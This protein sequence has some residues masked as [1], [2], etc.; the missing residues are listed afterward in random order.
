MFLFFL[1]ASSIV[2]A[3]LKK[4]FKKYSKTPLESNLSG[5]E[6]A[7]KMLH[8]NG[9]RN[10]KVL[11][12]K[13]HLSD[14]YNPANRTVNL[15]ESV[16]QGRN[17]A[18]ASVAAH[19]CGHAVQ[20]ARSYAPLKLRSVLVPLQNVS[21]KILNAV[22]ITMF[23]GA[24]MLPGFITFDLA[25]QKMKILFLCNSYPTRANPFNQLFIKKMVDEM[26]RQGGK[27][28]VGFNVVFYFWGNA[29]KVKNPLATLVKYLFYTFS[30]LI[31]L[32]RNLKNTDVLFPQGILLSTLLAVFVKRF[33]GL[34]VVAYVH[35]GDLNRNLKGKGMGN[36][37]IRYS[38]DRSDWVIANSQDIYKKVKQVSV[39]P[40]VRIISPG[41]DLSVMHPLDSISSLKRQYEVAE[42]KV[43]FLCAGNAIPRKGMDVLLEA[44]L[45]LEPPIRQKI[46]VILLTDGP[47]KRNYQSFVASNGLSE[48]VHIRG[49]VTPDILNVYNNMADVFV[50]PS[51]EEPLG[52]VGL[53]AMAGNALVVGTAVGGI[54]EFV[55]PG[56][57]GFL[58]EKEDVSAL[59]DLIS[60]LSEHLSD[61]AS[62]YPHI[63]KMVQQH[64]LSK[65]SEKLL[66]LFSQLTTKKVKA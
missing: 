3:Q 22:F 27:V 26:K 42:D 56:K 43:V 21:S 63:R 25:L 49:K 34:P 52:L 65:S 54:K 6:V 53:E 51:R 41:V 15:S 20:H 61:Y 38:L 16:Y 9:I 30:H 5:R 36:R 59:A 58:F 66:Q 31:F 46:Q 64:S 19:E 23:L 11:P 4:R 1:V 33:T 29:N 2:S 40:N 12:S 62:Y 17:V 37:L 60:H 13:G 44:V 39:N 24:F 32:V 35:G 47:L 8:D 7:E 55:I 14:H 18:A 57:T 50:F 28:K 45:S 48:V 10:V